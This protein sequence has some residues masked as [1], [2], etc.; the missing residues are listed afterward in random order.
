MKK[1]IYAGFTNATDV[2]DYM[3]K[4]GLP[5]RDAHKIVGEI[6]LY[7]EKENKLISEMKLEEYQKFSKLFKEDVIEKVSIEGCVKER[8]SYGGTSYSEVERQIKKAREEL[9]TE[10]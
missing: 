10:L 4:N 9:S 8:K 2:A 3:A 7:C 5:F 6:V 1:A